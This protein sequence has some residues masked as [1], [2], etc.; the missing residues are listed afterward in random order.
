MGT[1][2]SVQDVWERIKI[3]DS[4]MSDD[5][6]EKRITEAEVW[7]NGAQDK[8]YVAP[9]NS[10]IKY[11][12]SC[13]AAGLVFEFFF[14][15]TEPNESNQAKSLKAR[16]KEYLDLYNASSNPAESGMEK[17]NSDFFEV[18]TG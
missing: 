5:E 8:T 10:L 15:A 9:V 7:V 4:E 6:I 18:D 12:T 14:T 2:C 17:I 1:Y 16:A 13:Y 3:D 11:A